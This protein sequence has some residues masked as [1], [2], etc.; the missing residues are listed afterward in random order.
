MA[1]TCVLCRRRIYEERV[2]DP[3]AVQEHHL[4]PENRAESPTVE[5][6]RPCHDQIH[7]VFTNDELRGSY[8][9]VERLRSADRLQDYLEWIRGT[10]KLRTHVRT[11]ER[12]RRRD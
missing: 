9:T 3:G 5:L 12:V 6:C 2:D 4:V 10:Q 1:T 7:A 11:S 8:D